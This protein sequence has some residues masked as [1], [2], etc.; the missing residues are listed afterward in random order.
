MYNAAY[1]KYDRNLL[2]MTDAHNIAYA[3]VIYDRRN[4]PE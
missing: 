3:T 4:M 1:L 2:H